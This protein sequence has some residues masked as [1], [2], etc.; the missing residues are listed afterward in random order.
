MISALHLGIWHRGDSWQ[1]C[2]QGKSYWWATTTTYLFK[3]PRPV[4]AAVPEK[5]TYGQ[6]F[7]VGTPDA[8]AV[9]MAC[10]MAPSA[11]THSFNMQQR[12]I[13]LKIGDKAANSLTM[14]AP[15][16]ANIAPPGYYMLFL[17]NA[18]GVPSEAKFIQIT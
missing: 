14:E 3:G 12:Y 11:T 9:T 4:I 17:L 10:F 16:N 18:E 2:T 5:V 15:P 1:C 13:G 6:T 8:G 7:D